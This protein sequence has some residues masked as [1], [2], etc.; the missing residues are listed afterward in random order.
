MCSSDL[1]RIAGQPEDKIRQNVTELLKWVGLD[2]YMDAAPPVLSGGQK[3]RV[4]IA[5]A[6]ITRPRLILADEPTGNVDDEI[7]VRLMQLFVELHKL[8]S[9]VIVA[10]HNESMVR[11]FPFPR[12]HLDDGTLSVHAAA[13]A[14][15]SP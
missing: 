5:R 7:A 13:S 3:Q 14:E 10:T 11:R 4:A 1:L 2:G 8:G 12:L 15:P 6:V 9:C